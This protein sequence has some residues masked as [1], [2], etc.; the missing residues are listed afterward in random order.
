MPTATQLDNRPRLAA[1]GIEAFELDH[2][3]FLVVLGESPSGE[4]ARRL[5]AMGEEHA[6]KHGRLSL[7]IEA[8][9]VRAYHPSFRKQLTAWLR[10]NSAQ[11]DF[12]YALYSTQVVEMGLGI[13]NLATNGLVTSFGDRQRFES[14][15]DVALSLG[16]VNSRR[17]SGEILR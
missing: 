12:V 3:K 15:I 16:I 14:A 6:R 11:L 13:M 17:V 4:T 2:G 1:D 8:D 7:F 9:Q 5:I 10:S